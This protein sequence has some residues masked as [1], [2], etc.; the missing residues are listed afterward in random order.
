MI[1]ENGENQKLRAFTKSSQ[2]TLLDSRRKPQLGKIYEMFSDK[3]L[4]ETLFH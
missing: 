2:A 3:E 1:N 4:F